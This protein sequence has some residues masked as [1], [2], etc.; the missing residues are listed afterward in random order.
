MKFL[1]ELNQNQDF[2]PDAQLE[3]DNML[4]DA[5]KAR[6]TALEDIAGQI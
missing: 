4:L 3:G 2:D 1:D 6:M 5:L